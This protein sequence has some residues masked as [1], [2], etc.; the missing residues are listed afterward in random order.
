MSGKR[1]LSLWRDPLT[2]FL[3][4]AALVIGAMVVGVLTVKPANAQTAPPAPCYMQITPSNLEGPPPD[5]EWVATDVYWIRVE[6]RFIF[7]DPSIFGGREFPPSPW[8]SLGPD[9]A[10]YV[11]VK[12]PCADGIIVVHGFDVAFPCAC[13]Q[14]YEMR[15]RELDVDHQPFPGR[16]WHYEQE[17]GTVWRCPAK[18]VG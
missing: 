3:I 16:D 4:I 11:N 10:R 18:E 17:A 14:P 15:W 13:G 6:V 9:L 12:H 2:W 8:K 7:S 1:T 5:F